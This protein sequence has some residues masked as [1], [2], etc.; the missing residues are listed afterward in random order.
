MYEP[1]FVRGGL[2]L[3]RLR[4]FCEIVQAG[5]IT[6]GAGKDNTRQ[7][8]FSRQL[9][10]LERFFGVELL[11]RGR[12]PLR[13]T[14][15]G[16]RLITL[17]TSLL[18]GLVEFQSAC[19][20]RRQTLRIGAGESLIQWCLLPSLPQRT[21]DPSEPLLAFENRRNAEVVEGLLDG[22]LD[23]GVL[24][25]DPKEPRLQYRSLTPMAYQLYVPTSL[26]GG[27]KPTEDRVAF[28]VPL[29][30]LLGAKPVQ[31]ALEKAS[32]KFRQSPDVVLRLSSYPQLAAIVASGRAAAILPVF[33]EPFL[34]TA[35]LQIFVPGFLKKLTE[36]L[37]LSWNPAMMDVRPSIA[38]A[39]GK[40]TA[41][42]GQTQ[43]RG[44][45]SS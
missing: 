34:G 15:S 22:S 39:L 25:R 12:G 4:T 33:A 23:L 17:A 7:S 37:R 27:R 6:A 8:Q 29:A 18:G 43:K 28:E 31:D 16:D 21:P 41:C 26:L 35:P 24:S 2:S 45:K 3:E 9:R 40:L 14:E 36:P 10:E 30:I 11:V 38:G 32:R 44:T 1:L 19:E 13:L 20:G 5:G 42:W